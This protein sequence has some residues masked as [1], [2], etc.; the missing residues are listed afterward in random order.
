MKQNKKLLCVLLSILFLTVPLGIVAL[1]PIGSTTLIDSAI[2][3]AEYDF[4]SRREPVS[5][6][7]YNEFSDNDP[8]GEYDNTMSDL[9]SEYGYKF[10]YDNLTDYTHLEGVIHDYDV[11]LLIEQELA[12]YAQIDTVASAWNGFIS[13]W[14]DNGGV[15]ICMDHWS[16]SESAYYPT[17]RILNNTGLMR[18]YNSTARIG[19]SITISDSFDPLAFGVSAYTGPSGSSSFDTPDGIEVFGTGGQTVV[20]H[21]Y[22][23][24]GHVVMLGFDL[25]SHDANPVTILTNAVRLTRLAVFDNSRTQRFDPYSGYNDF[26]THIQENYGFAIATMNTWDEDMMMASEVFVSGTTSSVNPYDPTEVNFITDY[27][28][29]GRG[30]LILTDIGYFGNTTDTLLTEFGFE[31][32]QTMTFVGDTDDNEGVTYQPTFGFGNVAN[33]S[34]TIYSTNVQLMGPTAFTAIPA[35][36]TPLIWTDSDGTAVWSMGGE[37]SGLAVAASVHRGAGR[38]VAISDDDFL[39][40]TNNDGDGSSDFYDL[41]NEYFLSSIMVWLSAAGIPEKT[42][43]FE[44]SHTSS[45]SIGSIREAAW[46]LSFNGFNLRWASHFS[47]QLINEAD[48]LFIANGLQSYLA[49]EIDVIREYVAGGGGLFIYCDWTTYSDQVNPIIA[50]F[51]MEV[52][53]TNYLSD[54]DDGSV[55]SPPSSYIAYFD[56]N[57]RP[58]PITQGVRRIEIDRSCGFSEIGT[59]TALV[60][61]DIDGTAAWRNTTHSDLGAADAVPV[62]AATEFEFGRVVVLPD[63]NFLSTGDPDNDGPGTLYDSDND[64]LTANIFYWL[65]QNRAPIV[66]VLFPN[67]G[68]LLNGTQIVEWTALDFDSDPLIFNVFYSDNNGSDWTL[69]ESDLLVQE[70]EWNT[71]Q[72]DDGTSYMILVE[73]SDGQLGGQ[74]VSDDP[75]ELDNFA[76]PPGPGLPIDPLLLAIIGAGVVVVLLILVILMKKKGGGKKK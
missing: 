55:D 19:Q 18:I 28:A 62:I 5:V 65:S 22:F 27:V 34:A 32:N 2:P 38:M 64:V 44:Q 43:L 53:S 29:S 31:R 57:I 59:G 71:T 68:E 52:N 36:A 37:A 11:L 46:L 67:G 76:D 60:V 58:H 15:L 51:G 1:S 17:A 42:I 61:T 13:E 9:Q 41:N 74:D 72:H 6:L 7:V 3:A 12:S 56:N 75:F 50:E 48:I 70:Y 54:T 47:E 45:A 40:D 26:A 30:L 8:G 69:L 20:A 23:G 10:E 66:E 25:Y 63:I 4:E 35:Q 24:S 16:T 21:R 14:V 49:P 33:H 39:T 73:V